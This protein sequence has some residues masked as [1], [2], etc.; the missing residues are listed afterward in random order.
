VITADLHLH[1]TVSDGRHSP[2]ELV[3]LARK[4]GLRAIAI[5]DHDSVDG[6][7]EALIEGEWQGP[8]VIPG[9][10]LSTLSGD[11]EIHILGY[12]PDRENRLLRET[13]AAM[14]ESRRNRAVK[15]VEKLNLLG[16]DISTEMVAEIA[17][18]E[19]IGRPHIARALM[20]KGYIN[21]ISEAFSE[22]YIG[23]GGRAYVER[24]KL[25]PTEGISML[26]QADAIPVLA[27]PGYL[28]K[29]PPMEDEEIKCLVTG[30]LRGIEVYYSRHSA[31]QEAYYSGIARQYNLLVTGG[32]DCHG[33]PDGGNIL[34]TIRLPYKYV[35]ALKKEKRI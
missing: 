20:E 13:I 6:I 9:I 3:A 4:A 12:Y 14:I 28:S 2:S 21:N 35:E 22:G 5:T 8:E 32:S 23:R 11:R 33:N 10:E 26:L 16:I 18:G 30:G 31:E 17:G 7:E 34:G 1:T 19:F 25:T 15:M 27:H 29:G 24:L